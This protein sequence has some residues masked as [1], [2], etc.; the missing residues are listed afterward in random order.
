MSIDREPLFPPGMFET[1]WDVLRRAEALGPTERPRPAPPME[2]P[3]IA[4]DGLVLR[5]VPPHATGT[6]PAAVPPVGAPEAMATTFRA[7]FAEVWE[8]IPEAD[9]RKMLV[10]WRRGPT[11]RHPD[12]DPPKQ[13]WPLIE[14]VDNGRYAP[15]P[16]HTERNGYVISIPAWCVVAKPHCLR[17]TIARLLAQVFRWS[18]GEYWSL[19]M[20]LYEKPLDRW[21]AEEGADATDEE[22]EAR[23]QAQEKEYLKVFEPRIAEIVRTWGL[24]DP[25]AT[26][27]A[28]P[29]SA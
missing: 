29:T 19:I 8:R 6:G 27:Q 25:E 3:L 28:T 5:V 21:D 18:T 2:L 7:A 13:G 24:A 17:G 26:S 10:Y 15:P 11:W 14:I 4:E 22:I 12:D 16:L 23:A 1:I 9:R 20:E